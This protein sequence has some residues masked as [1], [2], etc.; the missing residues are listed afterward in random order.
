MDHRAYFVR[1]LVL[2]QGFWFTLPQYL[3]LLD[4]STPTFFFVVSRFHIVYFIYA[5][6]VQKFGSLCREQE[7]VGMHFVFESYMKFAT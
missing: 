7:V 4:F 2:V 5:S 3:S 6:S 1:I